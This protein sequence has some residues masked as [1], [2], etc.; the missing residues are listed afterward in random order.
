M[1]DITEL[2]YFLCKCSKCGK[3]VR[4]DYGVKQ[5]KEDGWTE[6][7]DDLLCPKCTLYYKSLK[8]SL[9]SNI[10]C[11]INDEN[12]ELIIGKNYTVCELPKGLPNSIYVNMGNGWQSRL[13][14][15]EYDIC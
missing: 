3:E 10:V 9:G 11:L 2:H 13:D 7:K 5:L 12:R 1:K 15:G 6:L 14:L 8:P 4:N